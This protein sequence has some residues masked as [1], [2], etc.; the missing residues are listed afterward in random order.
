MSKTNRSRRGNG[1]GDESPIEIL[2]LWIDDI[3]EN[4][5]PHKEWESWSW[6]DIR[7][8]QRPFKLFTRDCGTLD[9]GVS[10]GSDTWMKQLRYNDLVLRG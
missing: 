5:E 4:M 9:G 7:G 6:S 8:V 1:A 2:E 10:D 3:E